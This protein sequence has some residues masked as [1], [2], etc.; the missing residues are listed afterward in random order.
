MQRTKSVGN[1]TLE[2]LPGVELGMFELYSISL[3]AMTDMKWAPVAL[4]ILNELI[5]DRPSAS[6]CA[7]NVL[8]TMHQ[9]HAIATVRRM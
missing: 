5:V 9:H 4:H 7:F 2:N 6:Y 3:T 1:F 8:L